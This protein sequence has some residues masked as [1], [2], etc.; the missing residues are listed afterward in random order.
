VSTPARDRYRSHHCGHLSSA[1]TGTRVVVCGFVSRLRDH[2]GL[3]FI[4]LRDR[5]GLVQVV[6]DP[7]LL[8]AVGHL[9][10]E[11][12]LRV[13]GAV[14]ARAPDTVNPRLATGE[15]EIQAEAVEA[16]SIADPL[17]FQLDEDGVDEALRIR[18]R[19][20]DL[21]RD[22]M[23]RT[24]RTR[25]L[26]TQAI[27]RYLEQDGFWEL[28]TPILGQSTPEGARDFLVPARLWPGSFYALPQSPQLYKQLYMLAGYERYYQIARCFRDE[29]QRADRQL[30]FTQLD[31]EMAFATETEVIDLSEGVFAHV[32][33]E[34]AGIDVDRPFPRLAYADAMLRYG[35]DRPDLRYG[36]EIRDVSGVAADTSFEVFRA[37][38]SA[39]GVVR[40]LAVPEAA[41]LTRRELDELVVF[42]R[43]WGGQ[44]LA[45]LIFDPDGG[46]RSPI[47][48][49]LG[50]GAVEEI[51]RATG[52]ERGAT[53]FLVAD[54]A[55]VAARVMGALRP[56]LARRFGLVPDDAFAFVFV[57][58]FPAFRYDS[59]QGR[60]V[61][62]HHMFSAPKP[63]H[64]AWLETD[65]ERVV[66]QA[67]DLVING[68][69]AG[70]GSIRIH[71]PELQERV[72]RVLGFDPAAAEARFGFLLRALRLGAP[73]HGGVAFGLD[74]LVMLLTG[75]ESI[76]DVIAFPKIAGGFDPLTDAPTPIDP[77][78]L[79]ELGLALRPRPAE[80]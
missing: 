63:G 59:E 43:E 47:A 64:E 17:P 22:E 69:E 76:R 39:G 4:D 5:S 62:E 52:A 58:D 9:R 25:F 32:W 80:Q 36:L 31:I 60:L 15:I 45:W 78:Q 20:L 2:G 24:M 56:H 19:A 65:P 48:K 79:E 44:G 46:V 66:S 7:R 70:G 33:R 40:A 6:A 71:R 30:E 28:E 72:F 42:A 50:D 1:D 53:V 57:V 29:A 73:P 41:S 51:R 68:H 74:R 49:F 13:T 38:T 23:A 12:V 61:A 54:Q 37:A 27:R 18:H 14:V 75:A 8:A 55:A 21:R 26:A 77:E 35:T 11:S 67:Y 16:L 10:V 34:V 3:V